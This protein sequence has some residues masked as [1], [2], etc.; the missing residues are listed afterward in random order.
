M[1]GA[2]QGKAL[3]ALWATKFVWKDPGS[4]LCLKDGMVG[5]LGIIQIIAYGLEA[6]TVTEPCATIWNTEA[7]YKRRNLFVGS[8]RAVSAPPSS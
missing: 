1:V 5:C 3:P 8:Q 4:T 7:N 2:W 6:V